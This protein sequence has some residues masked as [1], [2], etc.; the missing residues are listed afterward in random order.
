MSACEG[1][2]SFR[3]DR[4]RYEPAYIDNAQAA[5]MLRDFVKAAGPGNIDSVSVVAWASPEG[6][7][8]HNLM[9]SRRRAAEFEAAVRSCIGL[10]RGRL[11]FTDTCGR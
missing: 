3:R 11:E 6:V 2:L 1:S 5:A 9:L 10:E 7:Y 8:E 4:Y